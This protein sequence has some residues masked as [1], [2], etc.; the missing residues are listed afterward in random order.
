ML[1]LDPLNKRYVFRGTNI[2]GSPNGQRVV[3]SPDSKDIKIF[4][5]SNKNVLRIDGASKDSLNDLFSQNIPTI[6]VKNIPASVPSQE[7]EYMVDITDPIYVTGNVALDGRFF[8]GY[9]SSSPNTIF[10]EIILKAYSDSSL[11]NIIYADYIYSKVVSYKTEHTF[12]D[13]KFTGFL[14]SGYNVLSLRLAMSYQYSHSFSIN[15][16][17]IT[18]VVNEYLSS[19]FANGISLGTSSKNLFSVMNRRVNGINSIQAILSDGTSGLRLDSNGLQSLRNGRWGM[20]PSII[21]YGR[22]YSTPSNAYIRRCKSYNGDI[23]TITR[24]SSTLGY[25]RMNIPSSWTADGFSEST[26]QIMLTGYGQSANGSASNM[27]EFLIKATVLSVTSSYV[28]IGLSDDD[29]GNDGEFYF[30]MKW[31]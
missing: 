5:D 20:V 17:S 23:P 15:N 1:E 2:I 21:C 31:L 25:L 28:Y 29:T 4:D 18:P 22:A 12:N 11:Q 27:S 26:V 3:I 8:G 10:V 19:L 13:E 7:R 16:M 9:T 24:M 30:E 6:N 14:V